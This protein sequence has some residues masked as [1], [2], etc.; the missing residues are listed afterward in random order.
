MK[1]IASLF[2]ISLL[3][4]VSCIYFPWWSISIVSFA[5]GLLMPQ[6]PLLSFLTAFLSIFIL[7]FG[8][9]FWISQQNGD[10]LAH[11][12]SLLIIKKDSPI[13]L[14]LITACMGA[15]VAGFSALSGALLRKIPQK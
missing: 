9:V 13:A 3:S 6:K 1:F 2:L 10:I 14:M 15:F 12:V 11:K 5:V 8:L 7:W 4:F